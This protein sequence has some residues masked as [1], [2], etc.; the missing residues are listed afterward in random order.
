VRTPEITARAQEV[1]TPKQSKSASKPP[2]YIYGLC[3]IISVNRDYFLE[4]R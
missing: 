3:M 2:F 1:L 4:K